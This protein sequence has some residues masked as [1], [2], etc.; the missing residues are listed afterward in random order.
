MQRERASRPAAS[1]GARP[2]RFCCF[3][4]L[5]GLAFAFSQ[6]LIA[7]GRLPASE[8]AS[9]DARGLLTQLNNLSIDS[10]HIYFLKDARITRDRATIYFNRGFLGLFNKVGGEVTGAAFFGD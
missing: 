3:A 7:P 6:F 9:P 1:S 4:A 10:S 5:T 8:I 2:A